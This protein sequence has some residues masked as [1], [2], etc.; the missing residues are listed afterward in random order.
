MPT[1]LDKTARTQ[2]HPGKIGQDLALW[3]VSLQLVEGLFA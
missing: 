1:K 2:G 3:R